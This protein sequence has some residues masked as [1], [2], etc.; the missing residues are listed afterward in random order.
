[1]W[2]FILLFAFIG[3]YNKFKTTVLTIPIL[4]LVSYYFQLE[5]Q[6]ENYYDSQ[7]GELVDDSMRANDKTTRIQSLFLVILFLLA[8]NWYIQRDLIGLTIKNHMIAR[9]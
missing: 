2:I 5:V 4:H 6:L 1:M 8:H 9:Q 3:N 7:S